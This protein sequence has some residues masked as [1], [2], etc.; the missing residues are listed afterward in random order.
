MAHLQSYLA[1]EGAEQ[2]ACSTGRLRSINV[3]LAAAFFVLMQQLHRRLHPQTGSE[4]ATLMVGCNPLMLSHRLLPCFER[5]AHYSCHTLVSLLITACVT[6]LRALMY[7]LPEFPKHQAS[8]PP[9]NHHTKSC[10]DV[11]AEATCCAQAVV[12]L[13]LPTHFLYAFLYYTDVGAVTFILASY[14]VSTP[15]LPNSLPT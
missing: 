13:M 5:Y 11:A 8:V 3:P 1:P 2:E 14:L 15:H 6:C 12:A 4:T 7:L 10:G 9:E